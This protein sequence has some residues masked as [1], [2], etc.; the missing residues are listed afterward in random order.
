[1]SFELAL[2]L[3]S[4]MILACAFLAN[5]LMRHS[6]ASA[7]HAVWT[8]A[9]LCLLAL[10]GVTFYLPKSLQLEIPVL[11]DPPVSP[12]I[13]LAGL[14]QA[15][16]IPQATLA[17]PPASETETLPPAAGANFPWRALLLSAWIA[18]FT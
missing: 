11:K 6:S 3:K 13:S 15:T 9:L 12:N 10:P 1:M 7:R 16:G 2:L 5:A 18:G 8:M 14:E 17:V 4:T